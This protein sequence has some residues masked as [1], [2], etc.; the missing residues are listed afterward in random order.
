MHKLFS[1]QILKLNCPS[2]SLKH[3]NF[4]T[5]LSQ[6]WLLLET[7]VFCYTFVM[8][9]ARI[10]QVQIRCFNRGNIATLT[11]KMTHYAF[12]SRKIKLMEFWIFFLKKKMH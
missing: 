7:W 6:E 9:W 1:V 4:E 5:D 10:L 8:L 11:H 3:E 12:F 2:K